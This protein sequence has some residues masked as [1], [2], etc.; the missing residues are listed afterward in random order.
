MFIF[1]MSKISGFELAT[2]E[3]RGLSALHLAWCSPLAFPT[4]FLLSLA[5]SPAT[6]A[7]EKSNIMTAAIIFNSTTGFKMLLRRIP[8]YLG[9]LSQRDLWMGTP[10]YTAATYEKLDIMT[11][12]LDTGAQ[13][14]IEACEHGTALMGACATGRLASVRFLVG[15]GA[16]TSYMQDGKFYSALLAAKHHPDVKRWLL[17]G[18]FLEGP[19]LLTYKDANQG[20]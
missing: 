7:S 13:L 20:T 11:L 16:R 10:L 9:L 12:L 14:E 6:Y 4:S 1:L 15:K 18:R 17:V 3:K 5:P 19:K 8:T 2:E